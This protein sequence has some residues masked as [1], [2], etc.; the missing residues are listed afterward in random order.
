[1]VDGAA[2]LAVAIGA[3]AI[4]VGVLPAIFL[5]ERFSHP[6]PTPEQ[7]AERAI[8]VTL[9]TAVCRNMKLFIAGF[10]TTL[11]VC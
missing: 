8:K 5:R 4:G 2:Y 10:A 7:I 3:L 9:W 11:K 1:M 6:E